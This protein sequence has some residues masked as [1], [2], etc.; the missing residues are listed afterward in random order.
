MNTDDTPARSIRTA[1]FSHLMDAYEQNYILLR[2]LFGD[3]RRLQTGD[4]S[5]WNA[6]V[7]PKVTHSS[8]Y[9]LDIQFTDHSILSKK[10]TPLR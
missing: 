10:Q 6:A 5:P 2:Q 1:A 4:E 3:L 8:R 7:Q 9:T